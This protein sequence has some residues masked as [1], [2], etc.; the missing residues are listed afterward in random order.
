[1]Q[2]TIPKK[3]TCLKCKYESG[4]ETNMIN[5][6]T[7]RKSSCVKGDNSIAT[8]TTTLFT[9]CQFCSAQVKT[10]TTVDFMKKHLETC[11]NKSTITSITN[12][13]I[14]NT[15]IQLNSYQQPYLS[16]LVYSKALLLNRIELL[17][18]TYFNVN[19]PQNHGIVDIPGTAIT[20]FY[21]DNN[22]YDEVP[23]DK[24][25]NKIS[26]MLDSLQNFLLNISNVIGEDKALLIK[27]LDSTYG[28]I[29]Q[30]NMAV[31]S[32][33]IR[34]LSNISRETRKIIDQQALEDAD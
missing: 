12:N 1:M 32:Q 25:A 23:C 17:K 28:E 16:H 14:I 24:L 6:T 7:K 27:E 9:A 19:I 2:A 8:Y 10:A 3:F 5:H 26:S 29:E 33:I 34:D 11:P 4:N 21:K 20:R 31:Y 13:Y 30:M 22:K 18:L 15:I